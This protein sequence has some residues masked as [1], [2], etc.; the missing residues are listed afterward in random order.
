[1]WALHVESRPWSFQIHFNEI[2]EL[3]SH[4]DVAFCHVLRSSNSM[5]DGPAKRGTDGVSPCELLCFGVHTL[6]PFCLVYDPLYCFLFLR[7]LL[8]L[9]RKKK[10][11]IGQFL[12]IFSINLE[13]NSNDF[14]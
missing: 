14:F 5:A 4:L 7:I 11:E 10:K 9:P 3:L 1:M 12:H 13:T 2:K 8:L 6:I